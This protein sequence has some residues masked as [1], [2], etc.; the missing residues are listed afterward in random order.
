MVLVTAED[1]ADTLLPAGNLRERWSA[2]A[3][4]DAVVVRAE[5]LE[6]VAKKVWPHLRE[7]AR[8]WTV[9]RT[10]RFPAPLGVL[11]AGLRP[12]A[13]CAIA[14]PEGFAQGLTSAGCAVLDT[15]VFRDH[16]T[17]G[18]RQLAEIAAFAKKLNAS[19]LVT[20]EKDFVKLS[21]SAVRQLEASCGPLM[22][23]ALDAVFE[24]EA[25]VL[26]TL[27]TAIASAAKEDH[28]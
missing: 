9:R 17:F 19:G 5:E 4:A 10:L 8:L 25:A 26:A 15:V 22:V 11:S 28:A 14:R 13:F 6:V 18:S 12:L 23:V 20:T 7:G 24:D 21:S 3:R 16:A 27:E 1:L 2:L